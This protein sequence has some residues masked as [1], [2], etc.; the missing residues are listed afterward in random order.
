MKILSLPLVLFLFLIGCSK[1]Q[2]TP[3][4][5]ATR[6]AIWNAPDYTLVLMTDGNLYLTKRQTGNLTQLCLPDVPCIGYSFDG[7]Y[8]KARA[9]QKIICPTDIEYPA[10]AVLYVQRR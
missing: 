9:T 3:Q 5:E 10:Y 1:I 4:E 2:L 6:R 7:L 8:G